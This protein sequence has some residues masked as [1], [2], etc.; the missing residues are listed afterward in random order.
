MRL[1]WALR[2]LKHG[3][4]FAI[5][6]L[7]QILDGNKA[8]GSRVDAVAQPGGRWAV[9]KDVPEMRVSVFA[10]HLDAG[11]KQR[12]VSMLDDVIRL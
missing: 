7:G 3:R 4:V 5:A 2:L 8:Q 9:R 12:I 1:P 6:F 10:A 11:H